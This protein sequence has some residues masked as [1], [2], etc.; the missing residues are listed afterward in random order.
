MGLSWA[1]ARGAPQVSGCSVC[2]CQQTAVRARWEL[3]W[4]IENKYQRANWQIRTEPVSNVI[5]CTLLQ[6]DCEE[7]LRP[8]CGIE[9]KL[10]DGGENG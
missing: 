7:A 2:T 8:C 3:I 10:E 1:R 5:A 6:K 9:L 4:G